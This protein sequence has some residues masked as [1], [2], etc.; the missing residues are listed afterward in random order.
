MPGLQL[1]VVDPTGL[2]ARPAAR[3]VQVANRFASRIVL[4]HNER[5][6]DAK[7]LIAL[8]GL[9]LRPGSRIEI[10]A[11][12]PDAAE[13]LAALEGELAP[14]V[15]PL[16]PPDEGADAGSDPTV[17]RPATAGLDQ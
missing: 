14:Y 1:T 15:Q 11:T 8:L 10:L 3:F 4:R 17:A 12:G 5:E 2:H 9:T 13:A 7:S 6:A 16:Q